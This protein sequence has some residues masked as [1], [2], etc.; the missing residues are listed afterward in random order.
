MMVKQFFDR[1]FSKGK[2][3]K[4]LKRLGFNRSFI[5]RTINRLLN[6]NSCKDRRRSGRSFSV[7]IKERIKRIRVKT[8]I[9]LKHSDNKWLQKRTQI[10]ELCKVS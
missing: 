10:A 5:Y 7:G 8:R 6:T 1:A 9:N 3:F 4:P 2:I